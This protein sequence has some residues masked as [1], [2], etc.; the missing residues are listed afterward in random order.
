MTVRAFRQLGLGYGVT[1]CNIIAKIDSNIV[2]SGAVSTLDDS[3][4]SGYT[5]GVPAVAGLTLFE[6]SNPVNFA[7]TQTM[8]IA[9]SGSPL[10][11]TNT[12]ATH[13]YEKADSNA[14]GPIFHYRFEDQFPMWDPLSDIQ[15]NSNPYTR[16]SE[17]ML[18]AQWHWVIPAGTTFVATVNIQAGKEPV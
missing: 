18:A 8:E 14:Y 2:Y 7:G 9:V 3:M 4:P 5:P 13:S 1:P 17:P 10:L 6:W 12:Q 15:I 11:L 16:P